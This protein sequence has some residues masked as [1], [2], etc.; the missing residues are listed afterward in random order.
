LKP[1]IKA[2]DDAA[3][4]NVIIPVIKMTPINTK[5]RTKFGKFPKGCTIYVIMQRIDPIHNIIANQLAN[6]FKNLIH[7]GVFFFSGS[8]LSPYNKFL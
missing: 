2:Y 6:S 5:P 3:W 8:L 7:A 4:A 1:S